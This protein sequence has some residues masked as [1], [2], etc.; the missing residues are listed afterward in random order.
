MRNILGFFLL[1]V[2][3]LS[4]S[5]EEEDFSNKKD[6]ALWLDG[7][8]T[9]SSSVN[10]KKELAAVRFL[11]FDGNKAASFEGETRMTNVNTYSEYSK[12]PEDPIYSKLNKENKLLLKGGSTIDPVLVVK[13][14]SISGNTIEVTLPVGKYF[15][16]AIL[17]SNKYATRVYELESRYNPQ[18]LDVVIPVDYSQYGKIAWQNWGD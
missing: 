15:V 11:F 16:V 4:C 2:L 13:T 8:T 14:S 12:L 3:L 6:Q 17:Y 9:S 5:S 7:Y 18:A 10:S 1:T